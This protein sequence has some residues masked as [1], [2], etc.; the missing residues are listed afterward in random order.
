MFTSVRVLSPTFLVT[1]GDE[2]GLTPVRLL[3]RWTEVFFDS[4]VRGPLRTPDGPHSAPLAAT[5][6]HVA[7]TP[8]SCNSNPQH[9]TNCIS[10]FSEMVKYMS[11]YHRQSRVEEA[12]D[13]L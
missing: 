12:E 1:A 4:R 5:I 13:R 7:R 6:W 3:G 10:H 9:I 11:K 2:A 8:L